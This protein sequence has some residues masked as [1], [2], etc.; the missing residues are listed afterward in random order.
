MAG[1]HTFAGIPHVVGAL[2]GTDIPIVPPPWSGDAYFNRKGY[3]SMK[4][5][6]VCGPDMRLLDVF[7]GVSGRWHDEHMF[8]ESDLHTPLH[9]G[10]LG[11]LLRTNGIDLTLP[12]AARG[13]APRVVRVPLQIL[14]DSAY[15]VT[16]FVLPAFKD[17]TAQDGPR[18]RFN[19]AHASTRN[20]VERAFGVLKARWRILLRRIDFDFSNTTC[21][22]GACCILHNLCIDRGIDDDEV[23]DQAARLALEAARQAP[24]QAPAAS[25]DGAGT[26]NHILEYLNAA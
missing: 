21:M 6:A 13:G 24:D 22:V 8:K 1:F 2:D 20:V 12:P 26:R 16:E 18:R 11:A 25:A 23:L 9:E 15:A 17:S 7:V 4:M 5:Q 19:A 14:A 10:W 3:T